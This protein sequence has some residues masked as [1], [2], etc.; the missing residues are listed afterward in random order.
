MVVIKDNTRPTETVQDLMFKYKCPI[1]NEWLLYNG[2]FSFYCVKCGCHY[3]KNYY[4]D[5]CKICKGL[6][7]NNDYG[8]CIHWNRETPKKVVRGLEKWL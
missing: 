6:P 4:K 2:G 5:K 3:N 8:K 7:C 1:C